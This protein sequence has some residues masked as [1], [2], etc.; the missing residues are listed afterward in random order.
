MR[1]LVSTSGP[2]PAN[3]P[4]YA[5]LAYHLNVS[6]AINLKYFMRYFLN[7]IRDR[8]CLSGARVSRRTSAAQSF[9]RGL[10]DAPCDP[11]CLRRRLYRVEPGSRD[12][13]QLYLYMLILIA[14]SDRSRMLLGCSHVLPVFC[15]AVV[16]S[17]TAD[18]LSDPS[19]RSR[20]LFRGEPPDQEKRPK[21]SLS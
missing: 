9:C 1:R 3:L 8:S 17:G 19:C 11:S 21:F 18:A 20:R 15:R 5:L 10:V 14:T 2:W 6:L 12:A 7:L 4:K 16:L 13:R